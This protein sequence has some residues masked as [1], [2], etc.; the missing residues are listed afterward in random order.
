MHFLSTT[1]LYVY[2]IQFFLFCMILSAFVCFFR[3]EQLLQL[4]LPTMIHIL[5]N[6]GTKTH[7]HQNDNLFNE[8]KNTLNCLIKFDVYEQSSRFELRNLRFTLPQTDSWSINRK[9]LFIAIKNNWMLNKQRQNTEIIE[10]Q[11]ESKTESNSKSNLLLYDDNDNNEKKFCNG[12]QWF[13]DQ[14]YELTII[15]SLT[16]IFKELYGVVEFRKLQKEAILA[17]CDKN[18]VLAVLPTGHGKSLIYIL[19]SCMSIE[20]RKKIKKTYNSLSVTVIISPLISLINDQ[21]RTLQKMHLSAISLAGDTLLNST[22]SAV[23][24]VKYQFVFISPERFV[25]CSRFADTLSILEKNNQ[26]D[27]IVVD[28]AHCISMWGFNFRT[29]YNKLKLTLAKYNNIPILALTAT[30]KIT[31]ITEII[32]ALNMKSTILFRISMNRSNLNFI[33]HIK[34]GKYFIDYICTKTLYEYIFI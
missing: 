10:N 16:A 14:N 15:D 11:I 28:E 23:G 25:H 26:L 30:A 9:H 31:T 21:I 29:S 32:N 19:A 33:V 3:T 2:F 4:Y 17:C 27:R 20:C 18:N 34:K 24:A 6:F 22:L 5:I 1:F 12:I 7:Q 13:N 8:R